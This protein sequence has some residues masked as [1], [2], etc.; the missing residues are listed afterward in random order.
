MTEINSP[1][2]I[3]QIR[4][5]PNSNQ[6]PEKSWF[7]H[8]NRKATAKQRT[9]YSVSKQQYQV[10][11]FGVKRLGGGGPGRFGSRCVA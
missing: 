11:L 2:A 5:H 4:K 10:L 7:E 3:E 8:T 9:K 1:V 6:N